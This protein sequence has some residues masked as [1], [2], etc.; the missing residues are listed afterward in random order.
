M[1]RHVRDVARAF[2]SVFATQMAESAAV[3]TRSRD[4]AAP[5]T[6][7]LDEAPIPEL[8]DQRMQIQPQNCPVSPVRVTDRVKVCAVVAVAVQTRAVHQSDVGVAVTSCRDVQ[9]RPVPPEGV[10]SV[11]SLFS[12]TPKRTSTSPTAVVTLTVFG[13]VVVL[14]TVSYSATNVGAVISPYLIR[15]PVR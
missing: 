7:V 3:V 15:R 5:E 1:V 11:T 2:Q 12:A 4:G 14:T 10:P 8:P 6:F 13:E 9:V